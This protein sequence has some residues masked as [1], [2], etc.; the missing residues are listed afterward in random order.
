M[1]YN[2]NYYHEYKLKFQ[3]NEILLFNVLEYFSSSPFLNNN[4][5]T[6]NNNNNNFNNNNM[7]YNDLIKRINISNTFIPVKPPKP[8][9]IYLIILFY[10]IN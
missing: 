9:I 10:F 3:K 1:I 4:N 5:N 6:N 8:F 2:I 7:I